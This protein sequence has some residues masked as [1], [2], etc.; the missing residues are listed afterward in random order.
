[1]KKGRSSFP[2]P[3][4]SQSWH[5]ILPWGNVYTGVFQ[6]TLPSE[7]HSLPKVNTAPSPPSLCLQEKVREI[8]LKCWMLCCAGFSSRFQALLWWKITVTLSARLTT[9]RKKLNRKW[10]LPWSAQ[11]VSAKT[12]MSEQQHTHFGGLARVS[13]VLTPELYH[14]PDRLS[15]V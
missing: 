12:M 15:P 13:S 10:K 8:I 1:M 9:Y 2:H 14:S 7:T 6:L 11:W 5:H 3:A 4:H